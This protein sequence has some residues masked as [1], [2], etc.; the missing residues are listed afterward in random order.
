MA[1]PALYESQSTQKKIYQLYRDYFDKA[2][3]KRRWSV[4]DGVPWDQCNRS[5]DPAIADVVQTFCMVELFLPDY[6]SKLLPQ[7]RA[8]QGRAWMLTNWGY[9]ESKHSMVLGDW[10]LRS[11]Q[12]TEEQMSDLTNNVFQREWDLPHDN[13]RGMLCYTMVQEIA[14]WL[15]YKNLRKV[16]GG[17]CPALD[18]VLELVAIDEMAH[19]DFFRRVVELHLEED[20][21]GTLEQLSRVVNTFQMPAIHLFVDGR[22]RVQAVKELRIF[23]DEIFF[24]E[25]YEPLL[26]K[27]G[28]T[29]AELRRRNSPREIIVLNSSV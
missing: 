19:H 15:H 26:K 27:I 5:L 18:R 17:Q 7:V 24:F 11:G 28:V 14:T 23:D 1:Q 10:L 9:E 12:R 2:E 29:R 21:P 8:Q 22:Q 6:V 13:A 20:R 25:I 16:V 4:R 3:K